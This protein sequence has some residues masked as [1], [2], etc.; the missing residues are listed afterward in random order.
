M[1]TI[2]SSDL[3][4]MPLEEL[5][6]LSTELDAI[7]KKKRR[8]KSKQIR[9]QMNELARVAGFE[10][11]EEFMESQSSRM[12]RSDKGIKLPPKYRN[13]GDPEQ[14]WSGKGPTPKWL[15]ELE[16]SGQHRNQFLI[17]DP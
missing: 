13:P 8:E 15:R 5:V 16:K 12:T 9:T 17:R 14:T 11:I 6:A 7:I 2:H 1:N 4:Q 3:E 10:S